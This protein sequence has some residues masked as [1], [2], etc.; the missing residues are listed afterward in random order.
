MLFRLLNVGPLLQQLLKQ[1]PQ[2]ESGQCV[3]SRQPV[4]PCSSSLSPAPWGQRVLPALHRWPGVTSGTHLTRWPEG[5]LQMKGLSV[6]AAAGREVSLPASMAP[7]PPTPHTCPP[8]T[9]AVQTCTHTPE[10]MLGREGRTCQPLTWG[11]GGRCGGFPSAGW[12]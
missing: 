10:H 5:T 4:L 6:G 3:Q 2:F 9:Y 11:P 12:G 7:H 8:C 1:S